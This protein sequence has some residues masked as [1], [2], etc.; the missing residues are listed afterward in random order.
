M[1]DKKEEIEQKDPS[2]IDLFATWMDDVV[3]KSTTMSPLEET[4]IKISEQ[5]FDGVGYDKDLDHIR[6]TGQML[7]VWTLMKKGSWNTL[8][9]IE[10]AT[11]FPQASIS[12]CL[13]N[14]RKEKFGGHTVDRQRREPGSG[15]WIYKLTPAPGV[16]MIL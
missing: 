6:L 14:F 2:Q 8:K 3:D 1:E 9:G 12:A 13:R 7:Q 15:T 16:K 11:G 4:T 5:K 10:L